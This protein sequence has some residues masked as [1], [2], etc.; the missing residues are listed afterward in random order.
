MAELET[1][2]PY[3]QECPA[4]R[5]G[6]RISPTVNN[7]TELWNLQCVVSAVSSQ[8]YVPQRTVSQYDLTS[9]PEQGVSRPA[10]P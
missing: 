2:S 3:H 8:P 10:L 9:R 4:T 7:R 6:D 1:R 5:T